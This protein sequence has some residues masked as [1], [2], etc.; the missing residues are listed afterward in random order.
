M[1]WQFQRCSEKS[2]G[3]LGQSLANAFAYNDFFFPWGY[4]RSIL[5]IEQFM[6][7]PVLSPR[8]LAFCFHVIFLSSFEGQGLKNL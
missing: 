6:L 7:N 4:N 2:I 5:L 3:S 8:K 1:E